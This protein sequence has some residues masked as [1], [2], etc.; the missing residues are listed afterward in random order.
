MDGW[1]NILSEHALIT[2]QQ[3]DAIH[4]KTCVVLKRKHHEKYMAVT[5][6]VAKWRSVPKPVT[7]P[8]LL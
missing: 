6:F 5:H 1:K 3:R 4:D 7:L 2:P 8:L